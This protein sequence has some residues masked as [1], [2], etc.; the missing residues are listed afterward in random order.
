MTFPH[1]YR[2]LFEAGMELTGQKGGVVSLLRHDE[3]GATFE[4]RWAQPA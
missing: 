4:V 1:Y 2:G 3:A